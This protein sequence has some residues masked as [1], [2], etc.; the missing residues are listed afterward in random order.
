MTAPCREP[1]TTPDPPGRH[2]L[3]LLVKR[4][5]AE[6]WQD[7]ILGLAA[8]AGFWQLL[9]L[10]PL[11]LVVLGVIGYFSGDLPHGTTADIQAF[12]LRRAA[13]FIS[14][15]AVDTLI[16]PALHQI[17]T[18]GHA[19]V[20][21]IGFVLALWSGSSAMATYVNTITIAYDLRDGRS[22]LRSR[23][24][25]LE[26]FLGAVAIGIL[27]LPL[28]VLGPTAI[29]S[30]APAQWQGD[31]HASLTV[32]YWPVVVL[33]SVAVLMTLYHLAPPVRSPWRRALPGAVLAMALWTGG[34][35]GL[36][37]YLDLVFDRN[38]V[39]ASLSSP[40]AVLLFFYIT[41]LAVLLG[42]ELN[43][44]IE[45]LWPGSWRRAALAARNGGPA[46]APRSSPTLHP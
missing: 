16:R 33:A 3:W 46:P 11:L 17:L 30:L 18:N 25:A 24:L 15:H 21:S 36:R 20:V 38:P 41:A 22:A 10:A 37:L 13:S 9:S 19:D 28:V 2:S 4:T 5:A 39:Y 34:S 14:P 43:A 6:A 12:L 27:L 44:E 8:E 1:P 26:L 45:R 31:V 42:A 32:L 7:R 35:L 23:V 29:T 40:V